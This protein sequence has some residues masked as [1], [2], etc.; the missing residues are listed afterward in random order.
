MAERPESETGIPPAGEETEPTPP[1]A[2]APSRNPLRRLYAWVLR[3]AETP[4]GTPA[5]FVL[6]FA[7]ASFF[8]IPPDVLLIALALGLP[9][10]A[11]RYALVCTAGSILGAVAGYGLGFVAAPLAKTLVA[12]LAGLRFYYE[13]AE[14]Y[15]RNAFLAIAVAG[16]T[17]IPYKVFTLSAGIFHEAVSLWTLILASLC[18]RTARFFLVGSLIFFFGKPVKRFIDRYFEIL[19]LAFGVLLVLGFVLVGTGSTGKIPP[20]KKAEVLISELA[21][22]DPDLRASAIEELRRI[23]EETDRPAPDSF[24]YDPANPPAENAGAIR[25]WERWAEALGRDHDEE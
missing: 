19:A 25:R 1:G 6:A 13:V 20:E 5:L 9:K 17:P 15:G 14:A 16:F 23:A 24:G 8:P 22:D 10:R 4:Y 11:F 21:H 3:W 2:S 18:S 12:E 7:E